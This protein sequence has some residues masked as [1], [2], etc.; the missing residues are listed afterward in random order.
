MLHKAKIFTRSTEFPDRISTKDRKVYYT[1]SKERKLQEKAKI[2]AT[3]AAS[4]MA[5]EAQKTQQQ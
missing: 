3:S 4:S 5:V 2:Y 1:I